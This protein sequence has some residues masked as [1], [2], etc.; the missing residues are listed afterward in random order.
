[1]YMNNNKS[2]V[3]NRKFKKVVFAILGKPFPYFHRAFS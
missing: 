2:A 1:M 3:T